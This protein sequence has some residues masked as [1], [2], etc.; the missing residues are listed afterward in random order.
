M[1]PI[2]RMMKR[3]IKTPLKYALPLLFIGALVLASTTGCLSATPSHQTASN[4]PTG[5][6]TDYN[7]SI[8]ARVVSFQTMAIM[9]ATGISEVKAGD[10]LIGIECTLHDGN[11]ANLNT[12]W[13]DWTA[14]DSQ[15]T[16]YRYNWQN[17]NYVAN[18]YTASTIHP[19]ETARGIVIYE[20]PV[21]AT[22]TKMRWTDQETGTHTLTCNVTT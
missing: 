18:S 13:H 8:S 21:N 2:A 6:G 22:I 16:L 4:A 12:S 1:N 5:S 19:G 3:Y 17:N 7:V 15:G 10:R 20:I 9:N 11:V 14:I